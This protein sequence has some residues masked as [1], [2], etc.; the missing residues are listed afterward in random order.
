MKATETNNYIESQ[1]ELAASVLKQAE[2]DLRRFYAASCAIERELY[3]DAYSWIMSDDSAWPFSFLNV[4]QILNVVPEGVRH[5]LTMEVPIGRFRRWLGHCSETLQR[6]GALLA[7]LT[8]AT[9]V[10]HAAEPTNL[11]QSSH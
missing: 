8:Q 10:V 4:C 5:D 1:R 6:V 7:C 11:N 9:Q 3:L 2:R